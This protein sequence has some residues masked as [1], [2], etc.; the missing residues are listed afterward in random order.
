ML[1]S[2]G[3]SL[4]LISDHTQ[5]QSWTRSPQPVKLPRERRGHENTDCTSKKAPGGAQEKG[6]DTDNPRRRE[7]RRSV[8]DDG[9]ARN[10]RSQV[11]ERRNTGEGFSRNQ[12]SGI[13]AER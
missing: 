8:G 7:T 10:Q 12:G 6:V 2:H 9:V 13:L 1:A 4:L 11:C 5:P 3:P